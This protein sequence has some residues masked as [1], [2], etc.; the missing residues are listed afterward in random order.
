MAEL[1]VRY[2]RRGTT[3]LSL[4]SSLS[5]TR[6]DDIQAD[7]ITR[8]GT[9]N[10]VNLGDAAIL[11]WE[12][13]AM[14]VLRP[15]LT[16][17]ASFL[18]S[19]NRVTGPLAE[20]SQRRNRRL[21]NTPLFSAHGEVGYRWLGAAGQPMV[22]LT[23]SFVGRSVLGTGD[24]F[25]IAQGRYLLLGAAAG[26]DWQRVHWSLSAEN[27]ANSAANRFSFGNPFSL[28]ARDQ[29]TP[30]RPRNVRLGISTRW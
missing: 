16:A 19:R 29:T 4:G 2:L 13:S 1:G 8:R 23:G 22:R 25:D 7:L 9:P 3:G 6:W 21:P 17:S 11:A 20:L 12:G 28:S 15:G 27:L 10:T 24:L 30:L 26:I 14:W 18:L 5:L